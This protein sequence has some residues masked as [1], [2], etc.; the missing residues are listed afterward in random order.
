MSEG[1]STSRHGTGEGRGGLPAGRLGVWGVGGGGWGYKGSGGL[2]W[3]QLIAGWQTCKHWAAMPAHLSDAASA[4][5]VT[6]L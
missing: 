4:W 3:L 1:A 6:D 5:G 2:A